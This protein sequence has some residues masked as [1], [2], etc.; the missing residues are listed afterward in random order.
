MKSAERVQSQLSILHRTSEIVSSGMTLEE[1][2][3][4]LIRLAVDVIQCEACLVYLLEPVSGEMA[5]RASQLPHPAEIVNIRIKA[6][7][8]ITGWVAEHPSVVTLSDRASRIR[9][10][11]GLRRWWRTR[12]KRFCRYRC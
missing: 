10:S 11:S 8:G 3:G 2:L 9:A 12:M 5:L 7:E 1:M 6:G 4:K